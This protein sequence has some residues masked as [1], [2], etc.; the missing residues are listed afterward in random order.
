M[1]SV[2]CDS[3]GNTHKINLPPSDVIKFGLSD[4]SSIVVRPSGTEP[5]L[6]LYYSVKSGS[7]ELSSDKIREFEN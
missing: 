1:K 3:D 7:K 6:K 2:T 4:G 5:K